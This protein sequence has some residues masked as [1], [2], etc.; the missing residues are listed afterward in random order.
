MSV[1]VVRGIGIS[2]SARGLNQGRDAA[3]LAALCNVQASGSSPVR[4]AASLLG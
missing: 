2:Q 3:V 4:R 1:V